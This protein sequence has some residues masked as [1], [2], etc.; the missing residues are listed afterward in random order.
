MST[1]KLKGNKIFKYLHKQMLI[2]RKVVTLPKLNCWLAG[3]HQL[4]YR[5]PDSVSESCLWVAIHTVHMLRTIC[6]VNVMTAR[7]V[8]YFLIWQ[9]FLLHCYYETIMAVP[10]LRQLVDGPLLRTRFSPRAD[11]VTCGQSGSETAF[12]SVYFN[13]SDQ[14]NY[15]N[16]TYS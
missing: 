13:F 3:S 4:I 16:V 11:Y 6:T 15:I 14:C 12:F 10:R 2:Q 5:S 1:S 9:V 8:F 7:K